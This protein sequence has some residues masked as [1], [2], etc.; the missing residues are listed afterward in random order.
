VKYTYLY[1]ERRA[2]GIALA[3]NVSAALRKAGFQKAGP[4]HHYRRQTPGFSVHEVGNGTE[5][6]PTAFISWIGL[7]SENDERLAAIHAVIQADGRFTA[8]SPTQGRYGT[9]GRI[10]ITRKSKS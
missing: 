2:Q 3:R 10:E 9:S 6:A 8:T 7:S 1:E 4:Y 5:A